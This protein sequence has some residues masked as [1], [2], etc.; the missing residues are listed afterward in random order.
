MKMKKGLKIGFIIGGA[1]LMLAGGYF[2][3]KNKIRK[4]KPIK[5]E[6]T[7]NVKPPA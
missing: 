6:N 5:S 7:D 4:N 3:I 2:L 1:L